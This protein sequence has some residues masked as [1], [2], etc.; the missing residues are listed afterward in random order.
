MRG[1]DLRGNITQAVNPSGTL[2]SVQFTDCAG[3]NDQGTLITNTAPPFGTAVTIAQLGS[4]PHY[5]GPG[6][7]YVNNAAA[8][9]INSQP[10]HLTSGSFFLQPLETIEIDTSVTNFVAIGK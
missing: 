4:A 9:K 1:C 7:C 3:Y 8:V 6:E 2:T 5:Y 10:T